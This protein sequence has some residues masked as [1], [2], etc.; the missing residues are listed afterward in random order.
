MFTRRRDSRWPALATPLHSFAKA[1]CKAAEPARRDAAQT[2]DDP[3]F[4]AQWTRI[5]EGLRKARL[6]EG[7]RKISR[8]TRGSAALRHRG[9]RAARVRSLTAE[10]PPEVAPQIFDVLD[11]GGKTQQVGRAR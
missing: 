9:R 8:R 7:E 3:T 6:P 5:V 1:N 10:R 2:T 4:K 11:S